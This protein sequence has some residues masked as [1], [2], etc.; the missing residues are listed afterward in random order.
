MLKKYLTAGIFALALIGA[1]APHA[2]AWDDTGHKISAYI[3]WQNMSPAARDE[4]IKILRSAPEDSHL[5]VYYFSG[6]RSDQAKALDLFMIAST[7]SDIVR[8]RGFKVR[9]EKYHQ[10]PWHYADIFWRQTNGKAEILSNR[11]DGLAIVK[12]YDLE[13]ILRE[14]GA[15]GGDKAIALAWF[16]H[17]AGDIHNPLHN[18][19]RVT[20]IEPEGD[21]GGNK[22]LLTPPDNTA[23]RAVNLHYYWDSVLTAN[24]PRKMDACDDQYI[25]K[26]ADKIM[27]K[28]SFASLQ[29]RLKTGD[30]R[31]WNIENFAFLN[32]T[33][34]TPD[35]ERGAMPPQKYQRR[36]LAVGQEQIALAGYRIADTLNRIFDK[37]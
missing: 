26:A 30:Y 17:I 28:H 10:G 3:A 2:R 32:D 5:G 23:N 8:D 36:A 22:F 19:S 25:A 27:K 20:E 34:Y 31:L 18:A 14:A 12:L 11:S 6:S 33:V 4:A 21:Q 13:K 37:Q 15:S 35:V 9:F 16:L 7:W 1:L 24:M 29:N